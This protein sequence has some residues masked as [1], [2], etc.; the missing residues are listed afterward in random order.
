MFAS[1]GMYESAAAIMSAIYSRAVQE[2]EKLA[3]NEQ[4]QLQQRQSRSQH[5]NRPQVALA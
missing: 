4:Q 5:R 3:A 1:A 2:L